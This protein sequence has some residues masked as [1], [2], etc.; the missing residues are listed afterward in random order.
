MRH[1]L[2]TNHILSLM[3]FPSL[4]IKYE[5]CEII[6]CKVSSSIE[7]VGITVMDGPFF[8]LMPFGKTGYH[9][10]TSGY[11]YSS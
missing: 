2:G 3:N 8:S 9:S 10:L 11:L 6:L 4:N 5:L 7:N 1:M